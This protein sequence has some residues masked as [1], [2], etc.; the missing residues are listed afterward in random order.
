MFCLSSLKFI[1]MSIEIIKWKIKHF[2]QP[3]DNTMKTIFAALKCIWIQRL[4]AD[5]R[6][7]LRGSWKWES[8]L[9]P[10]DSDNDHAKRLFYSFIVDSV[11]R[12]IHTMILNAIFFTIWNRLR[13][14]NGCKQTNLSLLLNYVIRLIRILGKQLVKISDLRW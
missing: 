4:T 6:T 5:D 13:R 8:F 10:I 14:L 11:A 9:W 1:V 3:S 2:Q 7:Y 12:W